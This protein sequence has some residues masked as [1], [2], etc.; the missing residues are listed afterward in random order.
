MRYYRLWCGWLCGL[1]ALLVGLTACS[2]DLERAAAAMTG[3]DPGR[4]RAMIR[5][6]G[7]N[8]CHVIPGVSGANSLV[9]PSLAQVASRVYLAGVIQNTP[10][11]M[12]RWLQ[13]PQ[14][15]DQRTAMPNLGMTEA[16]AR[17]IASYLYTLR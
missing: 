4:G 17:D 14:E 15:V 8:A 10:E 3:G 6:Y 1:I 7:C 13:N 9:G 2:Q 5:Q 16:A 11:G 12:I